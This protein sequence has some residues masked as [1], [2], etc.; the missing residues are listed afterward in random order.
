MTYVEHRS[1]AVAAPAPVLW[2]VVAGFGGQSRWGSCSLLWD[3]RATADRVIG[4]PGLRGRPEGEPRPGD[5]IHFWR[6][7]EVVPGKR[8]R[9]REEM[10]QLPGTARLTL[11]AVPISGDRSLLTQE[12]TFEPR[13]LLGHAVWFAEWAPHVVVFRTMLDGL[14]QQAEQ[15]HR[16]ST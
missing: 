5:V 10:R 8:L 6:V 12:V 11:S 16:G 15:R 9:L 14:A 1:R 13:G 4:G 2:Q 7:E 3:V